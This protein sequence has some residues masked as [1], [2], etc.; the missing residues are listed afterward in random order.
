[1]LSQSSASLRHSP[2]RLPG[3]PGT[4][5][6]PLSRAPPGALDWESATCQPHGSAFWAPS[7]TT[8]PSPGL[9]P[10]P[11]ALPLEEG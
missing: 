4:W 10:L 9:Q 3:L 11:T 6:L 7:A 1:M 8:F 2:S 5:D